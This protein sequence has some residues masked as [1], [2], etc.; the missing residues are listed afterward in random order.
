[1]LCPGLGLDGWVLAA[2][3]RYFVVGSL[4]RA[5]ARMSRVEERYVVES[6]RCH[7]RFPLLVP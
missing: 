3:P 2:K 1:M 7:P 6:Q 4:Y 5:V